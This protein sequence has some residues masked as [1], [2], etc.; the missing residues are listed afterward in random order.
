MRETSP[1]HTTKKTKQKINK[2]NGYVPMASLAG[3]TGAK[4]LR[5]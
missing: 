3:F 1:Q 5:L 2:G 4:G